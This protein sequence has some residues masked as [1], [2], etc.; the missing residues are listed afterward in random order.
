MA[1]DEI[2]DGYCIVCN[3]CSR[4]YRFDPRNLSAARG[5]FSFDE[6]D[7][8][9]VLTGEP[10]SEHMF[11]G[12]PVSS[13]HTHDLPDDTGSAAFVGNTVGMNRNSYHVIRFVRVERQSHPSV[14]TRSGVSQGMRFLSTNPS[15]FD[16]GES[17]TSHQ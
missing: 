16:I 2:Y 10:V 4:Y 9:G 11:A 14:E 5:W 6:Q 13:E 3:H 1:L 7:D 15:Q 17:D 12:E 8:A